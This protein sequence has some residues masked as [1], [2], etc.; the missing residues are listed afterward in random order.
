MSGWCNFYC[1][2]INHYYFPSFRRLYR[3]YKL[4]LFTYD[5]LVSSLASEY[6]EWLVPMVTFKDETDLV[7]GVFLLLFSEYIAIGVT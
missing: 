1:L 6:G 7:S 3:I 2:V 4:D 5:N